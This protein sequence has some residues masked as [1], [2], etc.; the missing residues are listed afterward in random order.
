MI[1]F[2]N[3]EFCNRISYYENIFRKMA[4]NIPQKIT[5]CDTGNHEHEEI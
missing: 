1:F 5:G 4:K 3:S 2:Q